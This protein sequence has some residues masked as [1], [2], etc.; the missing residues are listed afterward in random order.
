M[1]RLRQFWKIYVKVLM[2]SSSRCGNDNYLETALPMINAHLEGVTKALFI[3]FAGVTVDWDSYTQMVQDALPMLDITGIHQCDA[4]QSA[5][6]QASA[7]LVGGGNTFRL[8]NELYQQSLL[9]PIRNAVKQGTPYIGWSAGSNIC[10]MSIRTTNDMPIIEPPSFDALGFVPFQ[11]NPHFTDYQPPGHNGETRAQ[12]I[13]E[14]CVL[15]PDTPVIGIR[16]GTG[17][18]RVDN[19]LTLEG[20]LPGI[21][22]AGTEVTEIPTTQDLSDYLV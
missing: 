2:L 4:P 12:R 18:K 15:N 1:L 13:A 5:V 7:I 20:A 14:F 10:G 21:V 3:P 9:E 6:E 17:L 8:L 22:F 11:I 19:T 16:E